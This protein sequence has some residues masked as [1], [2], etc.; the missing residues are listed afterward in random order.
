MAS[1]TV[2]YTCISGE[3]T[4]QKSGQPRTSDR[5]IFDALGYLTRAGYQWCTLPAEF[6]QKSAVN[7]WVINQGD[8]Q[9][10]RYFIWARIPCRYRPNVYNDC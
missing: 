1:G 5:I 9:R 7:N 10:F 8:D 6:P 2:P 3:Q 4:A